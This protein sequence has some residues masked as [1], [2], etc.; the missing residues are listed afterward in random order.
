MPGMDG[1]TLASHIREKP[2]LVNATLMMLTSV[3]ELRGEAVR[4]RELGVNAYLTKPISRTDLRAAILATLSGAVPANPSSSPAPVE[5]LGPDEELHILLAEDNIVNQKVAVRLLEK[6]GHSVTVARTGREVLAALDRNVF[7]V[8]LMDV[9]MPDMD[10]L[11]ATIAIR[12][13][14][15]CKA[16]GHLPII[17][18]T[19]NA[20]RGDREKCLAAGMDGYISKPIDVRNLM[21]LLAR[22]ARQSREGNSKRPGAEIAVS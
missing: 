12:E 13:R 14:E 19:A 21:D 1:F 6:R 17:A 5:I 9:Q 15:K 2:A 8:V 11:E 16:E 3:G 22:Q 20:M 10:G 7:D 4:C 18:M